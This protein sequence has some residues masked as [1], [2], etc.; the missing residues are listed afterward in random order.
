VK[1]PFLRWAPDSRATLHSTSPTIR[2]VVRHVCRNCFHLHTVWHSIVIGIQHTRRLT[3][4]TSKFVPPSK[5][6]E[7]TGMSSK[8]QDHSGNTVALRPC[9]KLESMNPPPC[10]MLH[11]VHPACNAPL[12]LHPACLAHAHCWWHPQQLRLP[13]A[14]PPPPGVLPQ[15]PCGGASLHPA[16]QQTQRGHATWHPTTAAQPRPQG[17][18]CSDRRRSPPRYCFCVI[19]VKCDPLAELA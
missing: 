8:R 3:T 10:S 9:F 1:N 19:S 2:H 15:R 14:R 13:A 18:P 16:P 12:P 11:L 5:Y 6:P 7:T 17:A 4:K